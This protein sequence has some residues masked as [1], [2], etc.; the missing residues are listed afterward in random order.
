M[1]ALSAIGSI[2]GGIIGFAQ[3]SYQAK[4]A[5]MNAEVAN[6]N[7][8]RT[9]DRTQIEE[10]DNAAEN[11]A[12]IGEQE[13]AQG[14]SGLSINSES[15]RRIRKASRVLGRKDTLNIRQA[16]EIEKYNYEVEAA[17]QTAAAGMARIGGIGS[18]LS[19]FVQ[20]GGSLI[21]AASPTAATNRYNK[22]YAK[23][24]MLV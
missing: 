7:A 13:A 17:N 20:G 8:K 4:V 11:L 19:G 18:L 2:F 1:A 5:E 3:A 10:Q 12:L 9:I 24:R 21:G 15:S 16:G 23:P 14:A 6:D 22:P